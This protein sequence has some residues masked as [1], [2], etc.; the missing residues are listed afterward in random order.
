MDVLLS[1]VGFYICSPCIANNGA[2]RRPFSFF[3]GDHLGVVPQ[4]VIFGA[5]AGIE[6]IFKFRWKFKT[7]DKFLF[8]R[9]IAQAVRRSQARSQ[10]QFDQFL[11][12]D[13]P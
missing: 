11:K 9:H 2:R 1:V 10:L 12:R 6:F 4:T 3:R 5:N 7:H 13:E 8:I